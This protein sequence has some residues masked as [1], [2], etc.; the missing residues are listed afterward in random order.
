MKEQTACSRQV[1]TEHMCSSVSHWPIKM[2]P[3]STWSAAVG[4]LANQDVA[5]HHV[6]VL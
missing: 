5:Y 3:L 2:Q 4:W 1:V 6:T